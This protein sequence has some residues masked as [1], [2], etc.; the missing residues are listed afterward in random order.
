MHRRG[1]TTLAVLLLLLLLLLLAPFIA[2]IAGADAARE[3]AH[4]TRVRAPRYSP[5]AGGT[6]TIMEQGGPDTLDPLLTRT[7]AGTDATAP[8]FDALLRID[9]S[10]AFHPDLAIDWRRSVD[11]R[12]WTFRLN[13]AARWHDGVPVTAA[14]VAF[15]LRLV[16]DARFGATSTLGA[17]HIASIAISGTEAL[18]VTLTAAYAPFLATVG[19]TPILPSHVLGT[20]APDAVRDDVA[21]NRRPIGS[22]PFTVAQVTADGHVVEEANR[23]YFGTRAALDRLIFAP[24][25]SRA[26]ALTAARSDGATL[27]PPSLGL[28]AANLT[29]SDTRSRTLRIVYARSFA[30]THLDLIEHGALADPLVRRALA[31]ATPRAAIIARVLGGHGELSDGDQAPGSPAYEPALHGSLPY[32][33]KTARALLRQAGYPSLKNNK[34]GLVGRDGT[35]VTITLWGD[36]SCA[37]CAA[38]LRLIAQGWHAAGVAS[39]IYLV[40][41]ATLF[42][43]RGPLYNP[44]RFASP[45][46]DAVLYTWINGPDPDDSAYWTSNAAVTTARPL[47]GNYTGYSNPKLDALATDGLVTPN[48]PGRYA[49]YRRIQRIL[50]ADEP[51]IFL[52]WGDTLSVGPSGLHGYNPTPYNAA[53]TWNANEWAFK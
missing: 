19:L 9:A 4:Q 42:G 5:S 11:A 22:G 28:S 1:P 50:N 33:P 2:F 53:A 24:V 30:W 46:Y 47:G 23:D 31:L 15:T 12:T 8:V 27:V 20:L 48:G 32:N 26:D 38:T 34:Q 25:R 39:R 21:F 51:A 44:N 7:A 35:P 41:T 43:P 37:T 10:G 52:Y 29:A 18:T 17:D 49:I 16:R 6:L 36:Q 45:H 13:P 14:D 3:P 40:P